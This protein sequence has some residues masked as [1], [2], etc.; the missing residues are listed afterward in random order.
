M[1]AAPIH[2]TVTTGLGP[3]PGPKKDQNVQ[4]SYSNFLW[5]VDVT[6]DRR[7]ERWEMIVT[8]SRNGG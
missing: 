6:G 4:D 3:R 8:A 7:H 5:P 2:T 1:T